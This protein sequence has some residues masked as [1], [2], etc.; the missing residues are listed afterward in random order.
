MST[1]KSLLLAGIASLGLA[2]VVGSFA[3]AELASGADALT[4]PEMTLPPGWTAEDMQSCMMAATP[5]KPHAELA[6]DAGEWH[7]KT[8]MW[9]TPNTDPIE[10]EG[11]MT[12]SPIL[13][14]RF[15]KIEMIGEMPGMG[16][17]HGSGLCGFDNVTGKYVATWIDNWSTGIMIGKGEKSSD[18][19]KMSWTYTA[20]CPVAGKEITVR[21]VE[22]ITGP[23]SKT[24]EMFAPDPKTGEEFQ[25]MKIEFT[26]K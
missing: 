1:K 13:D 7:G 16:P 20:S 4:Q 2:V 23:D 24:L 22:T 15:M 8:T 14:G 17:Y 21:Q 5:G 3:T 12:V 26:R 11:V 10:S 19:K 18:G 25:T 6:K 9:M